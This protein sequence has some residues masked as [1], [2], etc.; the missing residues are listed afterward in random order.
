MSVVHMRVSIVIVYFGPFCS[1]RSVSDLS[2]KV[3]INSLRSSRLSLVVIRSRFQ[4]FRTGY[5]MFLTHVEIGRVG[6]VF[7][8]DYNFWDGEIAST[9]GVVVW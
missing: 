6:I 3:A 7:H 5:K 2:Q 9:H 8:Q 4:S 1:L